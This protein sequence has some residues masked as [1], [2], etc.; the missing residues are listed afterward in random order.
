MG[1]AYGNTS[2]SNV[3]SDEIKQQVQEI[4]EKI[5]DFNKYIHDNS[6]SDK[7]IIFIGNT[8]AGKSTLINYL[9]GNKLIFY[10]STDQHINQESDSNEDDK[11]GTDG[12]DKEGTDKDD[13]DDDSE[14]VLD[15]DDEF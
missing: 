14:E 8:G 12:D 4:K 7:N 9:A 6:E 11:E 3:N 13:S 5:S 10:K 1:S 2:T 15:E